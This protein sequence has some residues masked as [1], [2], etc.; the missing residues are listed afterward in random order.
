MASTAM[1]HDSGVP[2]HAIA[3]FS[4]SAGVRLW[5][6]TRLSAMRSAAVIVRS[7]QISPSLKYSVPKGVAL[8]WPPLRWA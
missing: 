4:K 7:M 8:L 1:R 2:C 5:L 6:S 3:R